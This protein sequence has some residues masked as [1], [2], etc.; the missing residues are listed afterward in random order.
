MA[1]GGGTERVQVSSRGTSGWERRKISS[2]KAT[3]DFETRVSLD[4]IQK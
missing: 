1:E 2:S 3:E 4:Y